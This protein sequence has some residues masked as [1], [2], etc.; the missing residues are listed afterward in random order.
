MGKNSVIYPKNGNE[1]VSILAQWQDALF[2]QRIV[3]DRI[4]NPHGEHAES[5]WLIP[6]ERFRTLLDQNSS[7]ER[8]LIIDI[9]SNH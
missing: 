9:D 4:S 2:T 7:H 5:V 1:R 6:A 3:E 8:N